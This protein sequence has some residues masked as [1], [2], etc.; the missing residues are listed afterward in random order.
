MKRLLTSQT[1]V[2]ERFNGAAFFRASAD[3]N[4][5]GMP[6]QHLYATGRF[7]PTACKRLLR[8]AAHTIEEYFQ[9][10]AKRGE[11]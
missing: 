5:I 2:K 8:T 3:L 9:Q 4:C 1:C 10:D 7:A 11:P 6:Q